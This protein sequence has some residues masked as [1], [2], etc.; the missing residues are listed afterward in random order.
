MKFFNRYLKPLYFGRRFYWSLVA[1][2]AVFL[3]AFSWSFLFRIG[4]LL[5]LFLVVLVLIDFFILFFHK[6]GITTKRVLAERFSNGDDNKVTLELQSHYG[7]KVW[8]K[9]IDEIP[10][11]FQ[12]R[13]FLLRTSLG[14]LAAE[15]LVYHLRPVERGEYV[16]H[17]VNV[18]VKSPLGLVVRRVCTPHEQM[19]KVYPSFFTLRQYEIMAWSNNLAEA[20]SRKIRKIGHSLEFEQIKEYVTGDDIRSINWKATARKGGQLMVNNFMDERSQQVYCIIDKGRVMKMPFE[21][22]TLLDYAIN[23][24]LILSRVALIKQDKAGLIT[25]SEQIGHFL[26]ADRKAAQMGAVLETLYN[27]QTKFLETDFEK[28]YALVRGRITQRSLIV[29]FT[30]F[31]SMD[32][33]QRQLPYIR[34]IARTHLVLVVFFENTELR[35]LTDAKAMDVE[36][37]YVK[38]I[39]EKFIHEKKLIV[40]ELQQHGITCI[41]TAPEN[42]TVNTVNKYLELKARQAI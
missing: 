14:G 16:F 8:L 33:L 18:Y 17:D 38:T 26:P 24:T 27:Q 13:D 2:I 25:F 6:T 9:I 30:N 7:F 10:V 32:G 42:L 19:I 40:K 3:V 15:N 21:G 31:E 23:A 20:G 35:Q 12:R 41:L 22:M 36:G 28:L 4:Q 34:S 39:A 5:F 11:Q 1:V 29:L 37:V